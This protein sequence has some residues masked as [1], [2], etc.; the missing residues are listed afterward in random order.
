MAAGEGRVIVQVWSLV[1][2]PCFS[3]Q[4]DTHVHEGCRQQGLQEKE[5]GMKWGAAVGYRGHVG[6]AGVFQDLGLIPSTMR[7]AR[8]RSMCISFLNTSLPFQVLLVGL[9]AVL[10]SA[11]M[12]I[13][14]PESCS[15]DPLLSL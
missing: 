8:K 13:P 11:G 4:P 10:L 6:G 14:P 12:I 3:R 7:C 15:T 2:C 5:E 9:G 1:G